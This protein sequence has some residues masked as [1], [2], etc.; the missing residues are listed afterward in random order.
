MNIRNI[1]VMVML[2]T[3][4]AAH[5]M[6]NEKLGFDR[7]KLAG[8]AARHNWTLVEGAIPHRT[9][10]YKCIIKDGR[11]SRTIKAQARMSA[12]EYLR[13]QQQQMNATKTIDPKD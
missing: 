4:S 6:C 5:A 11:L 2:V 10:R 8:I 7:E 3:A 12:I 9:T 1:L 13:L